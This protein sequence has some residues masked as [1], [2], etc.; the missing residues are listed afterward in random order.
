L[1]T[2][3]KQVN[4]ELIRHTMTWWK[5]LAKAT[6][7][8]NIDRFETSEDYHTFMWLAY[9]GITFGLK[10]GSTKPTTKCLDTTGHGF[11]RW[12]KIRTNAKAGEAATGLI[13]CWLMRWGEATWQQPQRIHKAEVETSAAFYK[14]VKLQGNQ[15]NHPGVDK[16]KNEWK[17]LNSKVN[18]LLAMKDETYLSKTRL[19]S[20]RNKNELNKANEDTRTLM[21]PQQHPAAANSCSENEDNLVIIRRAIT[22]QKAWTSTA[23]KKIWICRRTQELLLVP[24]KNKSYS[25][26]AC[27]SKELKSF[28]RDL[29]NPQSHILEHNMPACKTSLKQKQ[30]LQ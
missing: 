28:K 26:L 21:T 20:S 15:G 10:P 5:S 17:L 23:L 19:K 24:N 30:Q 29:T 11:F 8:R 12:S 3:Q 27:K 9:N 22:K 18:L 6:V 14:T 25:C 4:V 13:D 1:W 7:L 16:A 2:C